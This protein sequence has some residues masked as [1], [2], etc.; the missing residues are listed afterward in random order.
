MMLYVGHV[1][2]INEQNAYNL[3]LYVRHIAMSRDSNWPSHI[4]NC[5]NI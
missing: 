1:S 5:P 2:F 4:G 3:F